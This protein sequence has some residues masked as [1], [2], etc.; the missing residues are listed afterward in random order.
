[1]CIRRLSVV[2]FLSEGPKKDAK[3]RPV[4]VQPVPDTKSLQTGL[5]AGRCA[6]LHLELLFIEF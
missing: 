2:F 3:G 1:M 4:F 5:R 6:L